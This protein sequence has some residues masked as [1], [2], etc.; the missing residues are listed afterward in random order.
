MG[1]IQKILGPWTHRGNVDDS[2]HSLERIL[3]SW[4]KAL[5]SGPVPGS[6]LIIPFFGD[7]ISNQTGFTRATL[8]Y[9][10][11]V[12]AGNPANE[13]FPAW[14]PVAVTA[15]VASFSAGN[16]VCMI[17]YRDRTGTWVDLLSATINVIN[18]TSNRRNLAADFTTDYVV[19][20]HLRVNTSGMGGTPR[21]LTIHLYVK[22]VRKLE[23]A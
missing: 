10:T 22:N 21:N 6:Y 11:S 14:K 7:N 23:R 5:E 15:S 20:D 12:A 16:V 19:S 1:I 4:H 13:D 17:Q 9:G 3:A 8:P 18:T 2:L